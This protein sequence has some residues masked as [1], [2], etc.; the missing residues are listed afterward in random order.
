MGLRVSLAFWTLR[1]VV[2]WSP[3]IFALVTREDSLLLSLPWVL[4]VSLAFMSLWPQCYHQQGGETSRPWMLSLW[5]GEG[6]AVVDAHRTSNRGRNQRWELS[7]LALP[8][9]TSCQGAAQIPIASKQGHS[10]EN[11]MQKASVSTPH[12]WQ[13]ISLQK[14]ILESHATENKTLSLHLAPGNL[15]P[16][17][18]PIFSI[19]SVTGNSLS[20]FLP[21]GLSI[22][23]SSSRNGI[24]LGLAQMSP[25]LTTP[26]AHVTGLS[27]LATLVVCLFEGQEAEREVRTGSLLYPSKASSSDTL[28]SASLSEALAP[29]KYNKKQAFKTQVHGRWI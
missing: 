19:H 1:E 3:K 28:L 26:R 18:Y 21:Q 6:G 14:V 10:L 5:L 22:P 15:L 9:N 12:R 23:I 20:P 25:P 17:C 11:S 7:A 27:S 8:V 13:T 16:R 4:C 29:L 24:P 2:N